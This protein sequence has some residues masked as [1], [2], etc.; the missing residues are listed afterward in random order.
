MLEPYRKLK[1]LSDFK[2]E[3]P[4]LVIAIEKELNA[5]EKGLLDKCKKLKETSLFNIYELP[6]EVLEHRC[7]SLYSTTIMK[8][9]SN[10]TYVINGFQYTDSTKSFVYNAYNE[11][12]N[13]N[14]TKDNYYLGRIVDYNLVFNDT[15]PNFRIEQEY[16]VSFW[17]NNFTEDLYPRTSCVIECIDSTGVS[18]NRTE[19]GMHTHIRTLDDNMA[20][21]E[22]P[23]N[24]K[25]KKDHLAITIWHY[26]IF[27]NKKILKISDLLIKPTKE[28]LYR[29]NDDTSIMFNNRTYL[30]KDK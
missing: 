13:L 14:K 5:D 24:V 21:I 9:N 4:F 1:I 15:L 2:N 28:T 18:Y 27:D 29:K 26:D 11:K 22:C 17:M 30:A 6:F 25:N 12:V 3:K 20:L 16:T 10:K 7:D 8:L 19:F 23:I